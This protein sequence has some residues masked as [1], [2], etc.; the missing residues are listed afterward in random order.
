MEEWMHSSMIS[1]PFSTTVTGYKF[2]ER[3]KLIC[4]H[5]SERAIMYDNDHGVDTIL[6]NVQ[7]ISSTVKDV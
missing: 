4:Y 6:N 5:G 2:F 7:A 3:M 1:F